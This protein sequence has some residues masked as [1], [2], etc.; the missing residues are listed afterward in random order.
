MLLEMSLELLPSLMC[1]D[2]TTTKLWGKEHSPNSPSSRRANFF[3]RRAEEMKGVCDGGAG[4][5]ILVA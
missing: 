5:C 2:G 3:S 1:C 4:A